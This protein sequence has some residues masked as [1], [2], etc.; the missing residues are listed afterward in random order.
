MLPRLALDGCVDAVP[1]TCVDVEGEKAGAVVFGYA[2][3][4]PGA[5]ADL[6]VAL[7]EKGAAVPPASWAALGVGVEFGL[8]RSDGSCGAEWATA[9][10]SV[11]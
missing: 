9:V 6:A 3:L 10:D 5:V 8:A 2:P 7:V 1:A 11:A 4:P